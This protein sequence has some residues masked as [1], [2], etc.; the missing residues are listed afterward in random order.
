MIKCITFDLDDTLWAVDPV[1]VEA[2]NT[3][4]QWLSEHA[5]AFVKCYQLNDFDH[6]KQR[7][8][9]TFPDISHS[10]TLIRLKQLEIGLLAAGYTEAQAVALAHQAFEVFIEARN[11]V[12]LFEHAR[13]MLEKLKAKGYLIGALSNGNAD[14]NRVGL[15]DIFDFALNAD[16][17]GKEKPHPLMFERMLHQQQLRAEQVIHI[18]DNPHHDIFGAKN[19]GLWTVWVNLDQRAWPD[20]EPADRAVTCLKDIPDNV[21][22]I[23]AISHHRATL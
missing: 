13:A 14:V 4:Y 8:L 16:G 18:G 15:G 11:Q 3:L 5:A 12:E 23:A 20:I 21:A 6:L 9:E 1:I 17:V 22:Q 10:V 7:A 19:A 2:N